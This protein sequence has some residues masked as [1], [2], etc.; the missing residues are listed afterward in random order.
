MMKKKIMIL[1]FFDEEQMKMKWWK[2]FET[3]RKKPIF[4]ED[5][6]HRMIMR[7]KKRDFFISI[8]SSLEIA[9]QFSLKMNKK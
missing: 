7:E 2:M 4:N 6:C 1:I 8:K 3:L 5:I 9:E